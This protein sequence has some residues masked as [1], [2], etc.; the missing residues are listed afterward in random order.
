MILMNIIIAAIFAL[1][2]PAPHSVPA[3]EFEDGSGQA[4]CIWDARHMGNGEGNSLIIRNGGTDEAQ[5]KVISHRRAH[6]LL[7]QDT[8]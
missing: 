7:D 4:K 1:F 2:A 6:R 3:C 8:L 5:Y